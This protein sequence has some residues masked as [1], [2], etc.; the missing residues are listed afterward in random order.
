MEQLIRQFGT[1][2]KQGF[3]WLIDVF[4]YGCVWGISQIS[5][6]LGVHVGA[7]AD[8]LIALVIAILLVILLIWLFYAVIWRFVGLIRWALEQV[9]YAL[10]VL[11]MMLAGVSGFLA[12]VGLV[13][14][15]VLWVLANVHLASR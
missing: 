15:I 7:S 12:S 14:A 13:V 2:L 1:W 5:R 3:G 6:L 11:I 4:V 9:A 8:S 10:G